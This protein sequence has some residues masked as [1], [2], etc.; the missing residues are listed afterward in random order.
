MGDNFGIGIDIGTS[1]CVS[2]RNKES[3]DVIT[4]VRNCYVKLN[5]NDMDFSQEHGNWKIANIHDTIVALGDDAMTVANWK[6]QS[7]QRPMAKGVINPTDDMA[8]EVL[9]EIIKKTL[10]P[11]TKPGEICVASIPAN[12]TDGINTIAHKAAAKQIIKGLGYTFQS[13]SEGF[14]TLMALAPS[15]EQNGEKIPF[16]GIA[17]SWGG[18]MANM[19]LG[20]R[21]QE[22]VSLSV[23]ESGDWIDTMV[24]G[25]FGT[26]DGRPRVQ[27]NEVSAFKEKYFKF[28]WQPADSEIESF[29]FVGAERRQYFRKMLTGIETFYDSVMENAIENFSNA[30]REKENVS[31][32]VPM[33]IVMAG[34]TCAPE[35]FENR[36]FEIIKESEFPIQISGVRKA[37]PE[38]IMNCTA[39]GAYIKAM[40]MEAQKNASA[41]TT[42]SLPIPPPTM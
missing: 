28:G 31:I 7:L 16:T 22:Q 26:K 29:G 30:L 24:S 14:A 13:I 34:G 19:S 3:K 33:E 42:A 8:M 38:E 18:G 5:S 15:I 2:M 9:A 20:Y 36:F 39:K 32:E 4:S 27:P 25:F 41:S 37:G 6:K 1:N 23:S 17:I 40:S 21:A 35:G 11:P 10:G 12:S